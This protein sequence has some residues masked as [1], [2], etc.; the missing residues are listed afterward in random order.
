MSLPVS[1]SM[2]RPGRAWA[3]LWSVQGGGPSQGCDPYNGPYEGV[4]CPRGVVHPWEHTEGR[5][6][7]VDRHP[8]V[9]TTLEKGTTPSKH[10]P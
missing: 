7:Q 10:T 1:G 5:L 3:I 9:G 8:L 2:V 6:P 4:V